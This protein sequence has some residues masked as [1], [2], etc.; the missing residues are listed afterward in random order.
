MGFATMKPEGGMPSGHEWVAESTTGPARMRPQLLAFV[1][2]IEASD[3]A[4]QFAVDSGD[5]KL[6]SSW[7]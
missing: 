1:L 4:L 2:H 6:E 7:G 5:Q 3:P